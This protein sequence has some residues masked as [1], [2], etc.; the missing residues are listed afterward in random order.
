MLCLPQLP[1]LQ[2]PPSQLSS[3]ARR[4]ET[5]YPLLD[6]LTPALG[7]LIL[8]WS[9][10]ELAGLLVLYCSWQLMRS[11]TV[12]PRLGKNM[13]ITSQVT[14][15]ILEFLLSYM[16]EL[17]A[18]TLTFHLLMPNAKIFSNMGDSFIKVITMLL[19]EFEFEDLNEGRDISWM[20]KIVFLLFVMLMSVVLINLVIGLSISDV[21]NLR[22][23]AHI[24][25]LIN[26]VSAIKS[27]ERLLGRLAAWR[28]AGGQGSTG[29]Q[30][31]L[32]MSHLDY[33]TSNHLHVV[34]SS[35]N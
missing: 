28:K 23:D 2:Q 21:G 29:D 25:K 9:S 12:F 18:F 6:L 13:F 15:T 1:C 31:W 17:L 33:C 10:R 5:L 27:V 26:T 11:L 32:Q 22:K 34:S 7:F 8:A 4:R 3:W 24:H 16:V 30:V 14:R 20:T 35:S 19:G